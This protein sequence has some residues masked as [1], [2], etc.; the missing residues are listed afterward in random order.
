MLNSLALGLLLAAPPA[1]GLVVAIVI[2]AIAYRR[3]VIQ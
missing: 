1:V 3:E 2:Y